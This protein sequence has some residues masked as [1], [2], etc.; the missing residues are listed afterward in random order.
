MV[1][2][3]LDVARINFSHGGKDEQRR[4]VVAVRA[5]A[6]A[7]GRPVG[8]LADLSG[9]K[10]RIESFAKGKIQLAE[11]QPFA[12]DTG[13]DPNAGN[14]REVG[15]AYKDLIKDVKAGDILLL[16]DGYIVLEVAVGQGHAHRM[17]DPRRWRAVQPQGPQPAGRRPFGAGADRQGP[18]I[19][20]ARR[21]DGRG[22]AGGVLRARCGR[23]PPRAGRAA[24]VARHGA[25]GGQDRAPRGHRQP[26]RDPRRGR[27]RHG[28]ARRPGRGDGLCGADRPAEDHHP[29]G[30]GAPIASSSRPRR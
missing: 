11:G 7:V 20:P 15:C 25:C 16:A 24:Q 8:M 17:R 26:Q 30:A 2:A 27:R 1:R 21:R 3:G 23:H 19:H 14:E 6:E 12:L 29:A 9:P 28:R 5:A 4:R 10:I 13:L 18:G 22:L